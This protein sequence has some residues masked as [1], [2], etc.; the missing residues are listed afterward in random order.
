M[1]CRLSRHQ[2]GGGGIGWGGSGRIRRDPGQEEITDIELSLDIVFLEDGLCVGPDEFGLFNSVFQDL[3]RQRT[4]AQQILEMLERGKS[5]GQVFD[6]CGRW[7]SIQ[8]LLA[9]IRHECFQCSRTR[10]FTIL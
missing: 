7:R 3:Q 8:D 9:C 1:F 2:E 4:V 5:I 10:P 6:F